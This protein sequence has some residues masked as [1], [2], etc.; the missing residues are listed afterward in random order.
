[1][2]S[3]FLPHRF[4]KWQCLF[5]AVFGWRYSRWGC[6]DR[7]ASNIRC[8]II[9]RAFSKHWRVVVSKGDILL[10]ILR[11]IASNTLSFTALTNLVKMAN[12]FFPNLFCQSCYLLDKTFGNGG[13]TF[14]FDCPHCFFFVGKLD[15]NSTS[16]QCS[17]CSQVCKVS[18]VSEPPYF[19]T[20]DVVSQLQRVLGNS[21]FLDLT[22]TLQ[23]A[24]PLCD[25]TDGS[26]YHTFVNE[27]AG[28]RHRISVTLNADGAPVFKSSATS[29]WPIQLSVNEIPAKDRMNNLKLAALWFGKSKPRM[30]MFQKAYLLT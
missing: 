8:Q 9:C 7:S 13:V 21:G 14:H 3:I 22:A 1:M 20:F 2:T 29:I 27:T 25:I 23:D 6:R 11:Y 30:D 18:S 12:S 17:H 19:I 15:V 10:M 24:S 5:S 16:F 26:M 28:V 4:S